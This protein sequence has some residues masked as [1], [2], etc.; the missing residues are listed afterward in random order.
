MDKYIFQKAIKTDI[1]EIL[2][3]IEKRIE[4]MNENNIDQWN[5][6]N[7]LECYPK[8]YFEE[9]VSEGQLYVIKDGK[10]GSIIGSVTLLEQDKRWNDSSQSYYIHNLVSDTEVSDIGVTIINFCEQIAIKNDKNKIRLDCQAS[11]Y[12]L[13]E[14][15]AKLGFE[16][17]GSVQDDNYTGNKREKKLSL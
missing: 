6:T 13:N 14:Y 17:I 10:F 16:Y 2:M 5:K 9:M 1:D 12:K 15:Y 11:N 8:E 4:W 7:Y 3:L